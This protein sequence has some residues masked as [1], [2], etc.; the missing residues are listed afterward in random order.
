MRDLRRKTEEIEKTI[1]YKEY[2]AMVNVALQELRNLG[3]NITGGLNES[4]HGALK[5][6]DA[7]LPLHRPHGPK[8]N[9][10]YGSSA[11]E[12]LG[13]LLNMYFEKTAQK[14]LTE[15]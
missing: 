13:E 12:M 10:V 5:I 3:A 9:M 15:E 7:V 2:V 8:H 14:V 4:S 11:R 1:K 6:D